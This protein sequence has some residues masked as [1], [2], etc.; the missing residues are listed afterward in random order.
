MGQISITI[1]TNEKKNQALINRISLSFQYINCQGD[2]RKGK[3]R[4]RRL[5]EMSKWRRRPIC[6]LILTSMRACNKSKLKEAH[7]NGRKIH[8]SW[9]NGNA[10]L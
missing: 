7:K 5:K 3:E 6:T 9:P 8:A 4:E 1:F 10:C 2:V